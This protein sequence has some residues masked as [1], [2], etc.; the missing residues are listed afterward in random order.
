MLRQVIRRHRNRRDIGIFITLEGADGSGKST[1]LRKLVRSLRRAGV[2]PVVTR[3][4]GGTPFAEALRAGL[5]NPGSGAVPPIAEALCVAAAR[6]DHL[7]RVIEPALAAGRIVLCD[8]FTD[9]TFAYQGAGR[10]VSRR[11]L[12][13]LHASPG[14]RRKP[15]L[16][17][18]FDLPL[19]AGLSRARTR[20]G[21]R[22]AGTR[23]DR[24]S[25][26]FHQRVVRGYRA[27]AKAEPRRV[28][29]IDAG[30]TEAVVAARVAAVVM[31]FIARRRGKR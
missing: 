10:G 23:L 3:E 7:A 14:L 19:G 31:P 24:E 29:V 6:A 28:K 8:R 9:A 22:R 20:N 16:T 5:L 2:R 12:T 27:I 18:L 1:Q 26:A 13:G 30:G 25:R 4:P 15:D 21:R 17:L 11:F